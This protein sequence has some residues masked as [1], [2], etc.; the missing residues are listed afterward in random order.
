MKI[1]GTET[2]FG[3]TYQHAGKA[4]EA[5]VSTASFLSHVQRIAKTGKSSTE[6]YQEYL[7]SKY[8]ANV[9][10]QS[11]G[12]DQKSMDTLG[13]GTAGMNNVVI[14]P[15]IMEKMISNP[16][17]ATY[18]E[19]KIQH[20]FD[21]LPKLEAELS[22]MGHEIH[23]CGVVIHS[24]G[25]VTEFV[26]GDLK[27]EVRAKIEAQVKA[28]Q[29]E[30]AERRKKYIELGQEAAEKRKVETELAFRRQNHIVNTGIVANVD[31]P[32]AKRPVLIYMERLQ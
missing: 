26:T 8:G 21:T 20:H 19:S 5:T 2:A 28:E 12:K 15:N 32:E 27:P 11:V 22:A 9:S 16:E 10:I 24:D 1:N 17:K 4:S 23:S 7:R 3:A 31:L 29:E 30:K 13:A 18:Y 14:A 25:T 6:Q